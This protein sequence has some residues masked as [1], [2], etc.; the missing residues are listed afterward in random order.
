MPQEL[1]LL[2]ARYIAIFGL[3][4]SVLLIVLRTIVPQKNSSA[5]RAKSPRSGSPKPPEPSFWQVLWHMYRRSRLRDREQDIN[6]RR[7]RGKHVLVVDPDEKSCKVL[8]WKLQQHGAKVTRARN[9]SQAINIVRDGQ[10]ALG[11][12][13]DAERPIDV[14]ISDALLP[15][16]S[17]PDFCEEMDQLPVV[18]VGVLKAQRDDLSP[19][20]GVAC[21]GKPYDP[22]EAAALAGKLAHSAAILEGSKVFRG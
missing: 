8:M 10:A 11:R 21:L 17:A 16:V 15:D 1:L 19:M 2:A 4:V 20:A 14:V 12:A 7:L 3:V 9:G 22:D 18:L 6:A 13:Q 5:L